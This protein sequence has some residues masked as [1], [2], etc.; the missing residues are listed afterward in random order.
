M[1]GSRNV[2]HAE[3]SAEV[4]VLFATVERLKGMT[5]KIQSSKNRLETYGKVVEEAIGP[6]YNNTQSL[7]TTD[8]SKLITQCV[9]TQL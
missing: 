6:I 5:K 8:R 4:E 7:Q 2:A 3:E 1:V 9:D